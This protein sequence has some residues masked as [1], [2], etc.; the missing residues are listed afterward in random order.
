M[1]HHT[2]D[3]SSWSWG[4]RSLV[5]S[6][7]TRVDLSIGRAIIFIVWSTLLVGVQERGIMARL[8][9]QLEDGSDYSFE[10]KEGQNT[11]GTDESND[12]CFLHESISSVHCLLTVKEDSYILRDLG[13]I[14]GTFMGDEAI[15]EVELTD[16]SVFLIG[17][18]PVTL[19]VAL[20]V[21]EISE[22]VVPA[23]KIKELPQQIFD[24]EGRP[25][26]FKFRE[27]LANYLCP[28]CGRYFCTEAV[29][30]LGLKGGKRHTY[31]PECG[32]EC[33]VYTVEELKGKSVLGKFASS[34]M[35]SLYSGP[36]SESKE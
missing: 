14:H 25:M 30:H 21:T 32:K 34:F 16:G 23:R 28:T 3:A 12:C 1:T 20:E 24:G 5:G 18:I 13:S 17:Q 27:R 9:V 31:C 2:T 10:L 33:H 22:V 35:K 29:N 4:T 19:A 7:E 15:L 8:I 26:C 36:S 11:I 6:I